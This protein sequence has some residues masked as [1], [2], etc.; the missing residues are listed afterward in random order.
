MGGYDGGATAVSVDG[1]ARW[2]GVGGRVRVRGMGTHE[3]VVVV[4]VVRSTTS[5]SSSTTSSSIAL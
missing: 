3:L 1:W 4:D 2:G 5:S